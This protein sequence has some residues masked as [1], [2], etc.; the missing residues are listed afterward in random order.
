MRSTVSA[1]ARPIC[2]VCS[3]KAGRL[4]EK[5][6]AGFYGYGAGS[7][8]P[9]KHMI[10]DLRRKTGTT[11]TPFDLDRLFLP[12]I[13]EA[14][15]CLQENIASVGDINKAMI[16]GAGMK[17]GDHMMGP[18]QIADEMGLDAV[19]AKMSTYEQVLGRRFHPAPLLRRKVM[20]GQ[21]GRKAGKGFGEYT[22]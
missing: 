12:M 15:F 21:L 8:E 9:V 18:L 4:G 16:A 17:R 2:W 6:G 14:V 3:S 13:N 5:S 11:G 10:E 1:C 7:D 19:L 22:A 20:A